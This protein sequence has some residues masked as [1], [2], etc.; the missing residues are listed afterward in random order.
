MEYGVIEDARFFAINRSFSTKGVLFFSSYAL[1]KS[2][3]FAVISL[4]NFAGF[5]LS[6]TL[7]S[8]SF[9]SCDNASDSISLRYGVFG[10]SYFLWI[11]PFTRSFDVSFIMG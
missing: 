2:L 1:R 5:R 10:V 4:C 11:F 3:S 7:I 8:S 9:C 6:Y